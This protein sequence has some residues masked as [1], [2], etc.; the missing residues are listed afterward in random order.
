M[1][2]VR[3]LPTPLS[4]RFTALRVTQNRHRLRGDRAAR[5]GKVLSMSFPGD[6]GAFR[7]PDDPWSVRLRFVPGGLA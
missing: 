1:D 2:D 4:G 3:A 7:N 6:G 5:R